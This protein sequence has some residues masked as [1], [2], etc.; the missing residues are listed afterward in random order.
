MSG[1]RLPRE[2]LERYRTLYLK[3]KSVLYDR[4]TELPAFPVLLDDLRTLLDERRTIGV[5]HVEIDNLELVES[6]YG[7]QVFDGILARA[8][9]VLRET[10]GD[11]LP[12]GTLVALDRVA[13]DRFLAFVAHRP[14]GSDVDGVYLADL[15]SKLRDRLA[16]AFGGAEFEG[17]SP[18]LEFR[19]G[20]ARLSH[21]PFARFERQVYS[22]IERARTFD[23]QRERRRE[24]S[25]GD[26]LAKI[27]R[28]AAV[29]TVFQPVVDLRTREVL[30]YEAFA[31]GPKDS[32]LEQPRTMFAVS[33]RV[34]VAAE[35]DRLCR[36]SALRESSKMDGRGKIFLNALAAS[37]DEREWQQGRI[38]E[39]LRS[40][41]LEPSDVILEF[42]ER[43]ADLDLDAF[44][45]VLL[46]VRER[47]FG[48]A[49]DDIG[50][51]YA[52]QEILERVRPDYLKLDV[53]L[54]RDVHRNLIKQELLH[55]LTRIADGLGS[56]VIAEGV[57]SEQEVHV[58]VEAGAQ[59][60]QGFLFAVPAPARDH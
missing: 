29:D 14:D 42:S 27:I 55:S 41:S 32:L 17:L 43:D 54:V 48:V 26:D 10:V 53:S 2:V 11:E 46:R 56:D 30:G 8:A 31:R 12:D 36:D 20:Q 58:L 28:D 51:G 23:E 60:G 49:L 40:V 4:P 3:L 19:T 52:G 21:N 33:T 38:L 6:L 22:A 13:G 7:W 37:I 45:N 35:L 9:E 34:G 50:T 24:L 59:Y 15:G 44:V 1:T 5:L 25:W 39:L 57:E 16:G 47:G 18:R